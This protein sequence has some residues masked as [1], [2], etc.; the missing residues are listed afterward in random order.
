MTTETGVARTKVWYCEHCDSRNVTDE[1][2]LFSD[3]CRNCTIYNTVDWEDVGD[4]SLGEARAIAESV[5][6]E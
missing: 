1:T 6:A 2:D 4:V 5:Q 3:Q